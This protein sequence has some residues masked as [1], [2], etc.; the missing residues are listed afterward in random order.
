MAPQDIT[1]FVNRDRAER[2][3]R[4]S[5]KSAERFHIQHGVV[6]WA[7]GTV[8]RGYRVAINDLEGKTLRYL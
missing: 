2:I 6:R 3:A 5:I 1:M 7:D 8:D 4:Q